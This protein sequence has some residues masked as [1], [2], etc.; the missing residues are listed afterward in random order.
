MRSDAFEND[1]QALT[2]AGL[3]ASTAHAQTSAPA[4]VYLATNASPAPALIRDVVP[5]PGSKSTVSLN[6]PVT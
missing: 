6:R 1:G 4:A 5:A 2:A 3:L